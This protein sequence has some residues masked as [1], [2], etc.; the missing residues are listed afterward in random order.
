MW[1]IYASTYA[2]QLRARTLWG[3]VEPGL[4]RVMLAVER[5]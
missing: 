3:Q 5:G 1:G 4:K 2:K